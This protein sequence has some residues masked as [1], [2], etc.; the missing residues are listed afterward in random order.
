RA[1][2][3]AVKAPAGMYNVCD[4]QPMLFAEY[5]Q[6]LAAATGAKKPLRMPA[7]LG[8]LMFGHV[9]EYFSRSQRVSNARL[10]KL[11]GWQPAVKSV[12]E[13][14]PLVA[15]ELGGA[16]KEVKAKDDKQSAA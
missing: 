5:L 3:A 7:F 14:W 8:K 11:A 12:L 2:A 6:A 4:D 10:K 9:W 13:G 1:V 16:A 15:T